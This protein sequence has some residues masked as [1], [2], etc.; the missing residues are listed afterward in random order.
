[1]GDCVQRY[2]FAHRNERVVDA[3]AG[4]SGYVIELV[5][6]CAEFAQAATYPDSRVIRQ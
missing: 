1:M 6:G 3:M 2:C 5:V 4:W